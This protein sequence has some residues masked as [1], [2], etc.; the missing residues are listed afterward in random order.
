MN[1]LLPN[2]S[3]LLKLATSSA[4]GL[5]WHIDYVDVGP[6]TSGAITSSSQLTP[7]SVN[8]QI[9]SISTPTILGSPGANTARN[10]KCIVVRNTDAATPNTVTVEHNDG[11][12]LVTLYKVTLQ[13]G[14]T[15]EFIEGIGFFTISSNTAAPH[16]QSSSSQT[17][18][19]AD[20]YLTGSA[21]TLPASLPQA[22]T[23]YRLRFDVTKT[24][25]GTATPI[26]SVRFGTNGSTAD[27]AI[28]TLTFGAGTAAA[29]T[30]VF[31]VFVNFR[32]VGSG[33]SAVTEAIA[34]L[35]SNL[36]TTGLSNAVK[37]VVGTSS[38]FNSTTANAIIG[39]SYNGGASAA[40]TIQLVRAE[41]VA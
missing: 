37:A 29:D 6:L 27:T 26:I 39:A 1:L 36:T 13:P 18:F 3:A 32:T 24:G 21:I 8:G 11:T 7:N 33:T 20:T 14:D 16:V 30:G 35:T 40:H 12:T 34:R 22:G 4:A 9:S 19:S 5:D 28:H 38:G 17:G 23:E 10:V 31:E 25:A 41:I 15:L 2:T